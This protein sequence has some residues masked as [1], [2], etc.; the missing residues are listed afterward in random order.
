MS[1]GYVRAAIGLP[2]R[3]LAHPGFFVGHVYVIADV[4]VNLI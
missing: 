3:E 4:L 2:A 1:E